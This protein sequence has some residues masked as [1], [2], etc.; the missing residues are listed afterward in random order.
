MLD[1]LRVILFLLAIPFIPLLGFALL[2]RLNS[3]EIKVGA[4]AAD[5]LKLYAERG[6]EP[7][8][9]VL[10]ALA[11]SMTR[12]AVMAPAPPKVKTRGRYLADLAR[13]LVIAVG[14]A[15]IAWWRA[16]RPGEEPGA[17]MI[18]ALVVALIFTATTVWHLVG[19]LHTH[20]GK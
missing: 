4:K 2:G 12:P 5:I 20:D 17:V 6:Q 13:D 3:R 14:A 8:Q 9:S 18:L 19:A 16:P 11:A 10:N 1:A 7:P 15:G